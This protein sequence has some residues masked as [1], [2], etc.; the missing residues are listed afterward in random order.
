MPHS[1]SK[2]K[3]L[4][5]NHVR[6]KKRSSS[7]P[8][9]IEIVL[10]AIHPIDSSPLNE[11]QQSASPVRYAPPEKKHRS[12]KKKSQAEKKKKMSCHER[13]KFASLERKWRAVAE[14]CQ[15]EN[16]EG[17]ISDSE[18][19]KIAEAYNMSLKTLR[20]TV[21]SAMKGESLLR[22]P[23][24]GRKITKF[25]IG[26]RCLKEI[27]FEYGGELSQ[28]TLTELV[29]RKGVKVSSFKF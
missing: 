23:G 27:F 15:K 13:V 25:D 24:S 8:R 1:K 14:Y 12:W 26:N 19:R 9:Q 17:F 3:S 22:K 10:P 20:R 5:A 18:A 29:N 6:S 11:K 7:G 16:I 28:L 2:L 4:A 21:Q